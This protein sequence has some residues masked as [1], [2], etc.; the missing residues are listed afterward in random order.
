LDVSIFLLSHKGINFNPQALRN[1]KPY[2]KN[3]HQCLTGILLF[4]GDY[5][6]CIQSNVAATF[7]EKLDTPQGGG[8]KKRKERI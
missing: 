8:E 3:G 7:S 4:K 5:P 6:L 2:P 1:G